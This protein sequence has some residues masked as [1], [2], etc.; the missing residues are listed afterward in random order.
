MASLFNIFL[1]KR[2]V[3]IFLIIISLL[4][5]ISS[6]YFHY[7][8]LDQ[9]DLPLLDSSLQNLNRENP[10]IV[11]QNESEVFLSR[12]SST[13]FSLEINLFGQACRLSFLVPSLDQNTFVL[14]C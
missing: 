11:H 7:H 9:A 2:P 6:A 13:V 14:R 10:L 4:I 8:D 12:C 1:R 5:P 3:Q